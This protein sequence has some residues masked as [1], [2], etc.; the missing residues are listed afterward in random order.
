MNL[1]KNS[2]GFWHKRQQEFT[3][4]TLDSFKHASGNNMDF[5]EVWANDC[6]IKMYNPLFS[7]IPRDYYK[8]QNII[9]GKKATH[10]MLT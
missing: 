2:I 5:P 1:G 7:G 10:W 8:Q 9:G 6:K 4:P 3:I